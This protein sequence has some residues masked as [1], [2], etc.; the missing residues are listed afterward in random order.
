M[1]EKNE[2]RPANGTQDSVDTSTP[3]TAQA[4]D[5]EQDLAGQLQAAREEVVL[6]KDKY[7][8][9][10][11]EMDNFRKRQERI[12]A[13]RMQRYKRDLLEKVLEVMDNLD[14]AIGYQDSMDRESLQQGM[15]M[16]QWQMNELLKT[17]GLTPV[18]AV[19]QPFDPH[20]HEAVESVP[21]DEHPEGIVV[22][23]IRKGY[24]LGNDMIRPARVKVSGGSGS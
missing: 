8:R 18:P 23:E 21:S 7:L 14:R 1:A 15:R 2:S 17:E 24:M 10:R 3:E 6:Y 19:G 11:A 5:S 22:E 12:A 9:E 16:V 20:L 13:D 4:D